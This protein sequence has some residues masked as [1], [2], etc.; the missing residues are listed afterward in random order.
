MLTSQELATRLSTP[1]PR[2]IGREASRGV[3]WTTL[4]SLVNRASGALVFFALARL[5]QPHEFGLVATVQVFS[6]LGATLAEAGLTRTLVQRPRLRPQHLDAALMI[7][8]GIGLLLSAA[9]AVA[10]PFI[11]EAYQQPQLTSLV[12]ALAVVPF[13]TGVSSVPESILRRQLKFRSLA[14]RGTSS[15]GA[16]GVIGVGLAVMGAGVWALVAQIVSQVLIAVVVLWQQVRWRPTGSVTARR[17]GSS[18]ASAPT[19][20]A[21]PCSTSSTG[22]PATS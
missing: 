11:A 1:A 2:S 17:C 14:L 13:I 3:F 5:L 22:A 8:G 9:M 6:V 19:C 7:S 15:V 12:L 18:L 16:S 21:S 4:Q 20:S 10:A